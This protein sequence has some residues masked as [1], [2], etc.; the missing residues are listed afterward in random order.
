MSFLGGAFK[1]GSAFAPGGSLLYDMFNKQKNQTAMAGNPGGYSSQ[2]YYNQY[3]AGTDPNR[4]K[5]YGLAYGLPWQLRSTYGAYPGVN[6]LMD[7]LSNPGK[8]DSTLFNMSIADNARNTQYQQDSSKASLGRSGFGGS[9]LG[10]AL[11]A[12]IGQAGANQAGKLTAEEARRRE[13]LM[14]SDLDLL[15][16]YFVNP[17]L[18]MY[19]ANKG[20]E[21]NN[22]NRKQAQQ[23]AA[24]GGTASL[25]AALIPIMAAACHTADELYGKGSKEAFAARAFMAYEADPETIKMYDHQGGSVRLAER[26]RHNPELRKE[27]RGIFDGF[28]DRGKTILAGL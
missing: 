18:S 24:I 15:N 20:V 17:K 26:I 2:N 10:A 13:D 7:I 4:N 21:I 25:M 9:G 19:G 5:E 28:V 22:A 8:T 14:R 1:V 16:Q 27:V 11:Q 6:T 3:P 12:A 23:G